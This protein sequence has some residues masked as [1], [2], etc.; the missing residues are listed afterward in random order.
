MNNTSNIID[1]MLSC[2]YGQAIGDAFGL[3]SEFMSKDE[4]IN[5]VDLYYVNII[6]NFA[7]Y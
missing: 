7:V 5:M 3:G 6:S 1:K 4:V 2:L